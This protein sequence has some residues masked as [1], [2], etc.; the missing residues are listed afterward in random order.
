MNGAVW[1]STSWSF[2]LYSLLT[3]LETYSSVRLNWANPSNPSMKA[4]PYLSLY[5]HSIR[6]NPISAQRNSPQDYFLGPTWTATTVNPEIKLSTSTT[7]LSHYKV[8]YRKGYQET[9]TTVIPLRSVVLQSWHPIFESIRHSSVVGWG[10]GFFNWP[11]P[12]S[13]TM[14][15]GSTQPLTEMSTRNLPGV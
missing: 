3:S 1:V 2:E 13:R 10:T 6:R 12:P 11:N 9:L 15:L 8:T 7:N 5:M 4:E 14:A